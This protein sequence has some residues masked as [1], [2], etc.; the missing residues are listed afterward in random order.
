[1]KL[2]PATFGVMNAE[3]YYEYLCIQRS[4]INEHMPILRELASQCRHITEFGFRTGIS[5]MAFICG[6]PEILITYDI[7]ISCNMAFEELKPYAAEK[8]VKFDFIVDDTGTFMIPRTD[9]LFIDTWHNAIQITK[10]LFHSGNQARKFLVFHD[11]MTFGVEG[12]KGGD[13]IIKPIKDFMA[14]NRFWKI[15]Y[16]FDYN[17]GLLILERK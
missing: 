4:D 12:E 17:N 10:E 14:L 1:M 9:M 3:E 13:G 11:T 16:H 6:S 7:D 15:K 5:T 8:G 2:K